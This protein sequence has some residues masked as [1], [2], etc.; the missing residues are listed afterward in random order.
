VSR[1][2]RQRTETRNPTQPC[3][4]TA[5]PVVAAKRASPDHRKSRPELM[6]RAKRFSRSA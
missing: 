4:L 5:Q 2:R 3:G 1:V 6:V